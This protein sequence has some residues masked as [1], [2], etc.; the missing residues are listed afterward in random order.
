VRFELLAPVPAVTLSR[1]LRLIP[2]FR[3]ASVDELFR[4]ATIARQVR[5][6]A[7]AI[8]QERGAP[9]EHLQVLLEGS[10]EL[11]GQESDSLLEPPAILGFQEVL[12]GTT[13]RTAVRAKVDSIALVMAAEEFR[14]LLSANIEL[15]QGLFRWLLESSGNGARPSTVDVSRFED[16]SGGATLKTVDKVL[17][18]QSL[19][20]FTR[21]DSDELFELAAITKEH[22]LQPNAMLFSEGDPASILALLSGKIE[23]MPASG[24]ESFQVA[25]GQCVGVNETLAGASWPFRGRV[26]EAGRALEIQ[27]ELFFELL[28]DRLD[29]LQT[30]FGAAF[31]G[32]NTEETSE[33]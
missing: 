19:P 4:I 24:R 14:T 10:C 15:A 30:I 26:T 31:Q 13:I 9:A 17:Y 16:S 20:I 2:L 22:E 1:K 27:H 32:K 3:F 8:V 25:A 28:S 11:E 21:A 18:L 23:L 7:R 6:P 33:T 12:E 29:L 5:Y